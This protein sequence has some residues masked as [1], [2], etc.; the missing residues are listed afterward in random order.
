MAYNQAPNSPPPPPTISRVTI[1]QAM[2]RD[3]YFYL[4]IF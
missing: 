2:V 3:F 4:F 1:K